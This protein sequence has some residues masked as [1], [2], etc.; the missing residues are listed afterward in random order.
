MKTTLRASLAAGALAFVLPL[1]AP[2]AAAQ[3]ASTADEIEKY[4]EVHRAQN[5]DF[6]DLTAISL[7][8]FVATGL[9]IWGQPR[10]SKWREN[11]SRKGTDLNPVAGSAAAA[12][13]GGA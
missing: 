11:R 10:L 5:I 3:G 9:Y 2:P 12:G 8:L 13:R 4:R 7:V 1:A 6:Y